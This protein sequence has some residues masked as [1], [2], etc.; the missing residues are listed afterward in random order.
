M[1]P[2]I[3]LQIIGNMEVCCLQVALENYFKSNR[4]QAIHRNTA[5][6]IFN[7]LNKELKRVESKQ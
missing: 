3:M 6:H 2:I 7:R 1:E 4:G 5:R